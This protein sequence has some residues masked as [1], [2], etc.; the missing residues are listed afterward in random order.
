MSGPEKLVKII[1][2][3][4]E[5]KQ[6]IDIEVLDIRKISNIA[7]YFIICSGESSPQIVAIAA[8]IGQELK[9]RETLSGKPLIWKGEISSNWLVLDLGDIITH[10]MGSEERKRYNLEGLW[11]K[12]IIY[13]E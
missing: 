12:A 9:K 11:S 5:T 4:A 10:L 1:V 13:H 8:A 3:A 7:D 6:A 2:D